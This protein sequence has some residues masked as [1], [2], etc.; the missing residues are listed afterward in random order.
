MYGETDG[1]IIFFLF[2]LYGFSNIAFSFVFIPFCNKS[3][4]VRFAC[5]IFAYIAI[6]LSF[7][8]DYISFHVDISVG[9]KWLTFFLSPAALNLGLKEVCVL[10]PLISLYRIFGV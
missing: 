8:L 1:V 9:V 2:F 10:R 6:I 3:C 7:L 4:L 5:L